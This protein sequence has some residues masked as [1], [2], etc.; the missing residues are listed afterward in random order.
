MPGCALFV[1]EVFKDPRRVS[2]STVSHAR[3]LASRSNLV[4]KLQYDFV[5]PP[6]GEFTYAI[7]MPRLPKNDLT[8]QLRE[9]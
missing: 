5:T 2:P 7:S 1:L 9:L 3:T 6:T 4:V 8:T